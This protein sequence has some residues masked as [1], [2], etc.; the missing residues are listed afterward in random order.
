MFLVISVMM[1]MA[2]ACS[3][4][5]AP[6]LRT[7]EPFKSK[8]RQLISTRRTFSSWRRRETLGSGRE[9]YPGRVSSAF[10]LIPHSLQGSNEDERELASGMAAVVS[11]DRDAETIAEGSEPDA[12]WDALG[13][14]GEYS[15]QINL[16]K[17]ILEPRLFHCVMTA[18]GKMRAVEINDFVQKV[19]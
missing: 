1:R 2:P 12:F 19:G 6:V 14:K 15:K 5:E 16:D 9:R 10:W 18:S 7:S 17:P 3:A 13:G 4:C 11:P 8:K